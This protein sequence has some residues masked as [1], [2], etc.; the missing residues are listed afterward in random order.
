MRVD[1]PVQAL[2]QP[3]GQG[4]KQ[5]KEKAVFLHDVQSS[6]RYNTSSLRAC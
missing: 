2:H 5:A 3:G 4:T 6:K 1:L